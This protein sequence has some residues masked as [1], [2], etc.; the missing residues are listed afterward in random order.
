MVQKIRE[1]KQ[2]ING[3]ENILLK[4][5]ATTGVRN[6]DQKS[7]GMPA[8]VTSRK[9][10]LPAGSVF[11]K[12]SAQRHL[13]QDWWVESSHNLR[14]SMQHGR[15]SARRLLVAISNTGLLIKCFIIH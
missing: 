9:G 1:N 12:S 7:S 5:S 11:T 6:Y 4:D 8:M 10:Q 13:L 14:I 15:Q 2:H 3:A